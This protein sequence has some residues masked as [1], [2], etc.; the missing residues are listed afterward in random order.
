VAPYPAFVEGRIYL[1][2]ADIPIDDRCATPLALLVHE[3]ATNA[4]KYGSLGQ[5]GGSVELGFAADDGRM[6]LTWREQGGPPV[7]GPPEKSGFGTMLAEVSIRQQLGGEI[8]REWLP[9]GLR[10]CARIPLVSLSR[11]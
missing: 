3:L 2:G 9:D 8:E 7:P 5:A 1:A 11:A 6:I 4:A 10:V